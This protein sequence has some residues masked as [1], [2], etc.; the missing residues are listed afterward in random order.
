MPQ[1][2]ND[3]AARRFD[4]IRFG[5][6]ANG[7]DRADVFLTSRFEP[8][9]HD[10]YAIGITTAGV[11]TFNYRGG[12]HCSLPGQLHVLHPDEVH[13]GAPGTDEG[14]G[15]RILYISPDLVQEALGA[16]TIP[17]VSDPVQDVAPSMRALARLIAR[18]DEP[19]EDLDVTETVVLVAD[20]LASMARTASNR[21]LKTDVRAM[22]LVR[23]YLSTH[24]R[25][26]IP[27]SVLERIAGADR[28][29]IARHFH[30]LYGTSPSRFRMLQR[31][32]CA[33]SA[34]ESGKSLVTAAAESGF[35]DQ[36][37]MTRQFRRTYGVTPG[38]WRSMTR[39][40]HPL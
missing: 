30:R 11:Q 9:R 29:T 15:Y 5:P 20:S 23:D 40:S 17:F 34:I 26:P 8:H 24:F 22:G 36:S 12:H 3:R 27:T 18:V 39:S 33:R 28:F 7:I 2:L 32:R 21:G 4:S 6:G 14:F 13:D 16:T 10:T 35:A 31:V 38:R 19:L 25:K 37:H 1:V